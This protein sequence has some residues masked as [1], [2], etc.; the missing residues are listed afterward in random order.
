MGKKRSALVFV[1][2]PT[3]CYSRKCFI[4]RFCSYLTSTRMPRK[5]FE[6]NLVENN[7]AEYLEILFNL[8]HTEVM[9]YNPPQF[10]RWCRARDFNGSQI[11]VT[12]RGYKLR[13]SDM[14]CSYLSVWPGLG[15][16]ITCKSF[17]VQTLLSSL[18]LV[19]YQ[20][21]EYDTIAASN[22][23]RSWSNLSPVFILCNNLGIPLIN[24]EYFEY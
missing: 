15:D 7:T 18:E 20:N 6:E 16:F 11:P 3:S 4:M 8:P 14:Q 21:L 10:L 5:I 22:V 9:L 24:T 13:T 12:T 1:L 17:A 2:G 23:A 19:I